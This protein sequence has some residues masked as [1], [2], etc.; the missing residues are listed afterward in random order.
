MNISILANFWCFFWGGKT[1]FLPKKKYFS[2]ERKNV[3][4][5]VVTAQTRYVVILGHFLMARTF[6]QS[7]LTMVQN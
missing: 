1:D 5:S 2:A 7:F 3:R 4:F 6:P